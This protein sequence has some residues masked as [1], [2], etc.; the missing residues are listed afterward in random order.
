MGNG[1][2][3]VPSGWK[4]GQVTNGRGG[5]GRIDGVKTGLPRLLLAETLRYVASTQA[6]PLVILH[7]GWILMA[8]ATWQDTS[9]GITRLSLMISGRV[10]RT[11]SSFTRRPRA[12]LDPL[13]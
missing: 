3:T 12:R 6:G 11:V 7:A 13:R 2:A 4:G 9:A 1:P 10:P 5:P 8:L